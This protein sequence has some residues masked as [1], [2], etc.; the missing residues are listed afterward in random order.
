MFTTARLSTTSASTAFSVFRVA[1]V[2]AAQERLARGR[3]SRRTTAWK[4]HAPAG[5]PHASQEQSPS[6]PAHDGKVAPRTPGTLAGPIVGPR[7]PY[8]ETMLS[9]AEF[10]HARLSSNSRRLPARVVST[11]PTRVLSARSLP[12]HTFPWQAALYRLPGMA[13]STKL[14]A[15]PPVCV[16]CPRYSSN[17]I[18]LDHSFVALRSGLGHTLA[19]VVSNAATQRQRV[20]TEKPHVALKA[21][22]PRATGCAAA[23]SLSSPHPNLQRK[24]LPSREPDHAVCAAYYCFLS[25]SRSFSKS[26]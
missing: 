13:C 21:R 5:V 25:L 14:S 11:T 23:D 7:R 15:S 12:G 8:R 16:P 1:G 9:A 17:E 18:V 26:V 2:Q 22:W 19:A 20:R 10:I 4:P 3:M 24:R 6:K